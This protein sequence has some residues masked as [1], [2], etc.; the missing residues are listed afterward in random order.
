[1]PSPFATIIYISVSHNELNFHV[2]NN[3]HI[4]F[5]FP[6][7]SS[8]HADMFDIVL[9]HCQLIFFEYNNGNKEKLLDIVVIDGPKGDL[10]LY[11]LPASRRVALRNLVMF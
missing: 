2:Y 8:A 7:T 5:I 6:N 1:M 9:L 11:L 10:L 4:S 3:K